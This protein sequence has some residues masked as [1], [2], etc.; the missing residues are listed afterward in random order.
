MNMMMILIM[1][2]LI[3]PGLYIV[4]NGKKSK[5]QKDAQQ[6]KFFKRLYR[7]FSNFF[8]TQS[9]V[10][11]VYGK[12][13]NLSIYRRDE[14]QVMAVKYFL[15][16]WGAG[17][18]L[19]AA[20]FFMFH[21]FLT[22]MICV[23]F[24]ILLTTIVVDKQLDAMHNKVLKALANV[25]SNIRQ[26]YMRTNS[27]VESINDAEIPNLIKKPMEEINQ[28]L[29]STNAELRLQEFCESTPF[30]TVQTLAGICYH[31]NN[32]GDEIDV[33]GQSNFIQA[34]TLMLSDVNSE[35]Q[36]IMY[37]KKRFGMIEYL[38]FLPIFGMGL[39]ETYFISIMPGT[40]LIYNGPLGYL[41]RTITV[42]TS[43]I[44]YV[45]VSRVNSTTPIK[46][47]DR[48]DWVISF[49]ER[50]WLRRIIHNIVPKNTK[51]QKVQK[52]LKDAISRMS[53]EQF[54]LK[55]VVAAII[56]LSLAVLCSISTI[57]L[58]RDFIINSTQQLSLVATKEMDSY[59]KA[60]I[61]KL[62]ETYM[63][64]PGSFNAQQLTGLVQ[65]YMGGLSDLQVQD[66]VKRLKDKARSLQNA[67][68]KWWYI[69]V[70]IFIGYIG[71]KAPN[72]NLK[73]RKILIETEEE[74][75]F[76]QLQT[77]VSILMNTNIDTLDMLHQLSQHSRIHRDM[78][79]YAY[80]GY[81]SNPELELSRLQAKTPLI[82]FKRFI[83]KLKLS[84]SDLS[85]KEAYSDLLIEREHI[86]RIRDLT[87]T[88]SI[89]RKRGYCGPLSMIPLGAMI[90]GEFLVPIGLL[91]YN[92]F[93]NALQ[94]M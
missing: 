81:A 29:V 19:A 54:Y 86:L 21:D 47:D 89:D 69:W 24:S 15:L 17:L 92:E 60:S 68:F 63:A 66:Q 26:E 46:E 44:A 36:K 11:S 87:I 83:G 23:L 56:A 84:I 50:P 57:S 70:C 41:F 1:I 67:Y 77:L 52:S 53:I 72:I 35:L 48:G 40:A 90:I 61:K 91:G 74:D 20:S 39:I 16:S 51:G 6:A 9:Y 45:V 5:R 79:L 32:Q 33:Y 38:P 13:A 7:F 58:G 62:D 59:G 27:V 34:L 28:I 43:I 37:R 10:A 30:R 65:Q 85:L 73:I 42:V 8:L 31:I 82:D 93:V 14:L 88:A 64:N 18:G 80:Q 71:W 75:D 22:V 12:L 3:L 78:F 25:L 76:L 94:N 2:G 55:K 4:I 49:L